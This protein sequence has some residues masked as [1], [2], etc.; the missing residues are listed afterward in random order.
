MQT[1]LNFK[2]LWDFDTQNRASGMS[3]WFTLSFS[4]PPPSQEKQ[5]Q[6]IL[7]KSLPRN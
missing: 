5:S 7:T 6:P 3:A 2:A 4:P 1:Y